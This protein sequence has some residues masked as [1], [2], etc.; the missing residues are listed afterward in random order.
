MKA[1]AVLLTVL[2]GLVCGAA[3]ALGVIPADAPAW[4]GALAAG[5]AAV[6]AI[7][8]LA[9]VGAFRGARQD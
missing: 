7:A 6:K 1:A 2:T 3:A 5:L 9:A 8:A 4:V